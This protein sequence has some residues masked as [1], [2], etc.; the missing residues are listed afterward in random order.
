MLHAGH[1]SVSVYFW[2]D[3]AMARLENFVS[4]MYQDRGNRILPPDLYYGMFI[5]LREGKQET[6]DM[7]QPNQQLEVAKPK[8]KAAS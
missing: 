5:L 1:H 3:H 2:Q 4:R 6:L 7:K 8:N